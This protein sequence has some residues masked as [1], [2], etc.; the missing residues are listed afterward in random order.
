MN[1]RAIIGTVVGGL[2][3]LAVFF[4]LIKDFRWLQ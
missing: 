3:V 2:I 4:F 1:T